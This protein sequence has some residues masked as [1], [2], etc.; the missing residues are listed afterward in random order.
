MKVMATKQGYYDL[1]RRNEGVVFEIPSKLFSE[2]W[3]KKL[4]GS[5]DDSEIEE[6][7]PKKVPTSRKANSVNDDVL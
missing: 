3:M 1:K 5:E 7:K 6:V 4:E 2:K